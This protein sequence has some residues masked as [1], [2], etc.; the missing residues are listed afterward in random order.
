M[1]QGLP[2]DAPVRPGVAPFAALGCLLA[3]DSTGLW[4]G[5][6]CSGSG[7]S[8]SHGKLL[9][10]LFCFLQRQLSFSFLLLLR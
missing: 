7:G 8:S 4:A 10:K 2:G 5:C 6:S 1:C 3:A 9:F